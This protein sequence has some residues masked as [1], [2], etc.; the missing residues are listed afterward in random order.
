MKKLLILG[1]VGFLI[2]QNP[3]TSLAQ[4]FAKKNRYISIGGNL[5]AMNYVGELDPGPSFLSPGIKFTRYNL[6]LTGLYRMGPRFSLRGNLSYGRIKGSDAENAD[7][8]DKNI[9]RKIRNLSFRGP[10]VEAKLDAV[11]DLFENRSNFRKRPD[12]TP[13][14]F[15]GV[16]YFYHNPEAE[17]NGQWYKLQP[18]QLE[19]K[20]YSLHQI[21]IPV[22]IG[23]RYKLAKNWDLAF[24]MGWRFTFTDYLDDVAGTYR[25]KNDFGGDTIAIALSDRSME[26]LANNEELAKWV[27]E[28]QGFTLDDRGEI[29]PF[30]YGIH[31]AQ[32]GD[33]KG[34]RDVYIVTGFHLTYIIPGRVICPKFR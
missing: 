32:R 16:A 13:Y 31:G 15:F 7:F 30:G 26:G 9:H 22:G 28:N 12:Y 5:N 17:Y 14:A 3:V 27:V 18:L 34:R 19:G 20:K 8:K 1:F 33:T 4:G 2:T 6:G 29:V 11:F 25:N 24:E 10:L 23:F 21:S